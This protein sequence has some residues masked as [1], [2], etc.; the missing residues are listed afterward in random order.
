[1]LTPLYFIVKKHNGTAA[2]A[3]V[4][5]ELH[6]VE[7]LKANIPIGN[8]LLKP[9]DVS[10]NIA[11][12]TAY[13]GSCKIK[14]ALD[15]KQR[16]PFVRRTLLTESNLVVPPRSKTLISFLSPKPPDN[17][18]F[19][20]HTSRVPQALTFYLCPLDHQTTSISARNDS[21]QSCQIPQRF[22]LGAVTEM[23]YIN[24]YLSELSPEAAAFP[25]AHSTLLSY[26]SRMIP[27]LD[28]ALETR[29]TNGIMVYGEPDVVVHF[30]A[31]REEFPLVWESQ[32]F[33]NIPSER[34]ITVPL[35]HHW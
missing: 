26:T 23:Y 15:A 31:L 16:G 33:V 7:G 19:F 32:G 27:S 28:P 9:E 12:K 22:R 18:D 34:W 13:I 8:D 3:S 14:I 20:F 24:C 5:H 11:A 2:Y 35:R 25:P 1:M 10:I 17:K 21:D 29:P 6:L 4:K 30:K